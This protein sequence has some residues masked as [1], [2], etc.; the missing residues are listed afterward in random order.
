MKKYIL[1]LSF[2]FFSIASVFS[3]GA[4][5]GAY[6]YPSSSSSSLFSFLPLIIIILIFAVFFIG[7]NRNGPN[8]VLKEFRL[9]EN[10]DEFLKIVGR[11]SGI[12]SWILSLCGIDPITSL[13]CNKQSIKFET[14]AIRYGKKTIN[15]PLVAV[16]GV[17]SGINKP[18]GLLILGI[19]FILGGIIGALS[20]HSIGFFIFGLIIGVISL[21]L[22]SLKK[23]M[24]FS[25]YNGGDKPIATICMKKSIIEGQSIDE[26]K[27]ESAAN[28]LNKAV[29]DIHYILANVKNQNYGA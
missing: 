16:T 1:A 25:I 4:P 8:L 20:I 6:G 3:M 19:I 12:L 13:S 22:Y 2:I 24:L 26:L 9:N 11:S 14:S 21:I 18:F 27:Y 5:Q 28:A 29:F 23:N 15:I 17:S 10:E 7:K